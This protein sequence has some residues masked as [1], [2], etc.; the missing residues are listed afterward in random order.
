MR[1]CKK[2]ESFLC[3]KIQVMNFLK[4]DF[5]TGQLGLAMVVL[6]TMGYGILFMNTRVDYSSSIFFM[7]LGITLLFG[8]AVSGY[9]KA[10]L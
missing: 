8:I 3:T 5:T 1:G 9:L 4:D 2:Y 6:L 7:D 10:K